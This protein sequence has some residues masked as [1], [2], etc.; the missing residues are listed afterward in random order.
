VTSTERRLECEDC[1]AALRVAASY[2]TTTCPYCKCPSVIE[3]PAT[4]AAPNPSLVLP[5]VVTED[6]ARAAVRAWT[7]KMRFFRQSL[8][9]ST[10]EEI[11]GV[12]LPAYLYSAAVY[13]SYSAEIGENYTVTETYTTTEN[14]KTVTKTRQVVK[15]EWRSLE[16]EHVGYATDVVVTASRGLPNAE[17]EHIEPFDTRLLRRYGPEFVSGWIAEEPTMHPSECMTAARAEAT[18]LEGRRLDAFMPGDS[19][20]D[21]RFAV[22][23]D[24]ESLDLTL[25]P[26]WVLALRPDPREPAKRVLVNGQ[27]REIWGPEAYSVWKIVTWILFVLTVIG[28]LYLIAEGRR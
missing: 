12:Y 22:K 5:F 25:I 8:D 18:A 16:G 11:K 7:R 15:T 4:T 26:V 1:G 24:R 20:R 6:S 17:L 2:R 21:L 13:A 28:V 19:H 9:K 23:V 10:I 14:G 27:S 3:R